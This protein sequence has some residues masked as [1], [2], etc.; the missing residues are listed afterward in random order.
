MKKKSWSVVFV[1]V[2]LKKGKSLFVSCVHIVMQCIY[3]FVRKEE[4]ILTRLLEISNG[5]GKQRE[6]KKRETR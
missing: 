2:L 6:K 1:E 5:G 3:V 4:R